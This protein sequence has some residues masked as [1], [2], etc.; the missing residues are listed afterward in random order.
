M[1]ETVIEFSRYYIALLFGTG[2]AALFAGMPHKEKLSGLWNLY[3]HH[4]SFTTS[5]LMDMGH[6]DHV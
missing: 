2:I 1:I 3:H 6:G 4:I 5:F